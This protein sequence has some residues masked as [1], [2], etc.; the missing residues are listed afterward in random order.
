VEH[1][2]SMVL[3]LVSFNP[4]CRHNIQSGLVHH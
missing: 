3:P 2:G 4:D 1:H